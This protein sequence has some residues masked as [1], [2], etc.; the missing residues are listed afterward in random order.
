MVNNNLNKK[1]NSLAGLDN[2]IPKS[3]LLNK[4][5]SE[6]AMITKNS[7]FK[8][9]YFNEKYYDDKQTEMHNKL[10]VSYL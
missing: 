6:L 9:H 8:G 10:W 3:S 4:R 2:I 7:S 1:K 5:K